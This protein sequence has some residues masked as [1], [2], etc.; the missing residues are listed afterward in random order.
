VIDASN[1]LSESDETNNI[2]EAT[3]Y[4]SQRMTADTY[5]PVVSGL[6]VDNGA[7]EVGK[8][9]V[10]LTALVEDLPDPAN[11]TALVSGPSHIYY[12]ELHWYSGMG[13]GAG[14]WIPVYWTDWLHYNGSP[15][16][17]TLHP[18]PGLRFLQAWGADTAGNISNLPDGGS[19]TYIPSEDEVAQG[20]VRVYRREVAAGQC[21]TVQIVPTA[22]D[23]DPDLY[24]WPPAG[25]PVY[26]LNGAGESDQVTIQPTMVGNYQIEVEGFTDAAYTIT[27]DVAESCSQTRTVQPNEVV[28]KMPRSMPAIPVGE[29]PKLSEAPAPQEQIIQYLT[30]LSVTTAS[31]RAESTQSLYL[32]VLTR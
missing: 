15:I 18:T 13:G 7:R 8:R 14:S 9:E 17:F 16:N 27:I 22:A 12:V 6:T 31:Q 11:P 5:P 28:A 20:E 30:F 25:D 23:M 26:S 32:P 19:L 3:R 4:V 29:A 10:T 21:L 2:I 1:Q 24:V